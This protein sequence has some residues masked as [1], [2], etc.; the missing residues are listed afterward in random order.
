MR[1]KVE[2]G[3]G[4][5]LQFG[6]SSN[7]S[8]IPVDKFIVPLIKTTED[9]IENHIGLKIK[10]K[11]Y[12]SSIQNAGFP[13][14][15]VTAFIS[16]K[17]L[18]EGL[19]LISAEDPA[20]KKMVQKFVLGELTPEEEN[21]YMEDVLAEIANTILGNSLKHFPDLVKMHDLDTPVTLLA[22]GAMVRYQK[23]MFLAYNLETE[24]G[25]LCIG[26]AMTDNNEDLQ[27]G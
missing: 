13:L 1:V 21:D 17:G 15:K 23:T 12:I 10:T 7:T 3:G 16:V 24:N 4:T 20:A 9:F 11:N 2:V 22:E 6:L 27:E 8:E 25:N 5:E 26:L 18:A 19:F 14:Y